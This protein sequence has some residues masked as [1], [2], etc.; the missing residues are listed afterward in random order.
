MNDVP[1][2][3]TVSE[4]RWRLLSRRAVFFLVMAAVAGTAAG[5]WRGLEEGYKRGTP[6]V[7]RAEAMV[8]PLDAKKTPRGSEAWITAMQQC[9]DLA[10]WAGPMR[11]SWGPRDLSVKTTF[12]RE[13]GLLSTESTGGER[14]DAAYGVQVVLED[15]RSWVSNLRKDT[16]SENL[17]PGA[18]HSGA[19]GEPFLTVRVTLSPAPPGELE[20]LQVWPAAMVRGLS[21][22]VA[23]GV[24]S[25][26]L[27]VLPRS[28]ARRRFSIIVSPE[29]DL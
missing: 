19:P 7:C 16:S 9:G 13:Y 10:S 18:W 26:L 28:S 4:A 3:T 2:P 25:L 11:F 8:D 20:R 6:F 22:G 5:L 14:A 17:I 24:V 15:M 23:A 1:K 12:D 27:L 21:T 29:K